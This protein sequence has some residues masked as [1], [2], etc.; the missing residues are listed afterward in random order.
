[1]PAVQRI[2]PG[3]D[4]HPDSDY[5]LV[6]RLP[7]GKVS[8]SGAVMAETARRY[9]T[10]PEFD[11]LDAAIAAALWWADQNDVPLVYV[12]GFDRPAQRER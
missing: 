3:E 12:R 4:P 10:P 7:G 2:G 5:V 6:E 11:S 8:V 9:W 1:M